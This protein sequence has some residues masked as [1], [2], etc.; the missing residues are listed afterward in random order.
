MSDTLVNA[1]ARIRKPDEKFEEMKELVG[2]LEDNLNIVE[3]LYMRIN[4]RQQDL[5]SDY[6]N[7]ATSLQGLS[8]LESNITNSL[9]QFAETSKAYSKAMQEMTEKEEMQFLN[10][11]HALLAYCSAAKVSKFIVCVTQTYGIKREIN[12]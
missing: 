4:K 2:K 1:F 5:Q 3:R 8:S 9:H 12:K 7:F 10:E 11:I 6:T